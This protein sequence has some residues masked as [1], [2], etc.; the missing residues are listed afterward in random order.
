VIQLCTAML[1]ARSTHFSKN[2]NGTWVNYVDTHN[3]TDVA[4]VSCDINGDTQRES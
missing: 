2:A 4:Y 3:D 1:Q